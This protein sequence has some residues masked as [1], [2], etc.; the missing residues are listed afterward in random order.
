MLWSFGFV[1]GLQ[2]LLV[3]T[4]SLLVHEY[5]HVMAARAFGHRTT[6]VTV[7]ILGGA[8]SIP[9]LLM[10]K[11][12]QEA[13]VAAA[14]PVSSFIIAAITF[15]PCVLLGKSTPWILSYTCLINT[16]FGVFNTLPLYP[17]DGGRIL[18]AICSSRIGHERGTKVAV[19]TTAI[20]GT[21]M[22]AISIMLKWWG[23]VIIMPFLALMAFAELALIK[24]KQQLEDTCAHLR[25]IGYSDARI[26]MVDGQWQIIYRE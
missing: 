7:Y 9:D 2:V 17:M 6:D 15:L 14:G 5:A 19:W 26:E 16:V 10:M 12:R 24:H 1:A 25:K 21:L 3:L 20:L 4:A 13:F 11:P 23:V 18:R 22:L 8:A